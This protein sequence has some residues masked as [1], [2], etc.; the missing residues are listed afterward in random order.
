MPRPATASNG[1]QV[2]DVRAVDG[3]QPRTMPCPLIT[4]RRDLDS[5]LHGGDRDADV[6]ARDR[7]G[8]H[9]SM[10]ETNQITAEQPGHDG[11]HRIGGGIGIVGRLFLHL[12]AANRFRSR[13]NGNTTGTVTQGVTQNLVTT[14][15]R[16]QGQPD[17]RPDAGLPVD[18]SAGHHGRFDRSASPP[19][20]PG[21]ASVYAICQPAHVQSGPHQPGG[22]VWD[23]ALDLQQPCRH[24]HARH[25]QF[26]RVVLGA[27]ASR[28]TSS[29]WNC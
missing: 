1:T 12:P 27:R 16:H 2:L 29:R 21:A 24:H 11:D 14:V 10:R 15:T 4:G 25:G 22:A 3:D 23:G 6:Y 17:H 28:N 18:Q 5:Q 13:S 26:I 7:H 8:R 9:R 20:F 19:I